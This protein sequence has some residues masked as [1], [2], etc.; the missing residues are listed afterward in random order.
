MQQHRHFPEIRVKH[1]Q[2]MMNCT[3][4]LHVLACRSDATSPEIPRLKKKER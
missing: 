1:H 2:E 4:S 3:P